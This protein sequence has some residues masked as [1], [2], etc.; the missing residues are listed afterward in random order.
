MAPFLWEASRFIYNGGTTK[1]AY[2]DLGDIGRFVAQIVADPRTLN[3]QVFVWG[4]EVTQQD[5]VNLAREVSGEPVVVIPV[6][7]MLRLL[8]ALHISLHESFCYS[9]KPPMNSWNSSERQITGF[10]YTWITSIVCGS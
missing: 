1:T 3:R 2:I 9:R 5:L 6:S 4:E 8:I 7:V 10:K